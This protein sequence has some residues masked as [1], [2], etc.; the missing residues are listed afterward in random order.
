MTALATI[1]ARLDQVARDIFEG[2]DALR[3]QVLDDLATDNRRSS[4]LRLEALVLS[5]LARP[6]G[7]A[8]GAGFVVNPG[9]FSDQRYWLEWWTVRLGE[10]G[11]CAARLPAAR[12][13]E[14]VD[15]LDY[16]TL[17]WFA[18]PAANGERSLVGPYVDYLCTDEYT[19]TFTEPVSAGGEFLGV[20]GADVYVD[21]LDRYL[22]ADLVAVGAPVAV[23]NAQ[24]RVVTACGTD[25]LPGELLRGHDDGSWRRTPCREL[26]LL[27]L[28][29]A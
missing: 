23:T 24:G 14:A 10:S 7:A 27:V 20:V 17:P 3:V 28:S 1:V 26:P 29:R 8:I 13:P 5:Q 11:R 4:D 6:D 9:V 25:L 21:W 18:G 16:T 19:L 15:F 12:D 2:I 22:A